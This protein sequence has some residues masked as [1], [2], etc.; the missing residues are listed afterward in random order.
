MKTIYSQRHLG[1]TGH[2][3]LSSGSLVP[4]FERPERAEMIRAEVESR[5]IGPLVEITEHGLDPVRRVHDPSFVR[6][7]SEAWDLWLAEGRDV[8]ALPSFWR[9]PGMRQIEPEAIDGK[10][11]HFSFDAGCCLVSGS[12]DAIRSSVDVALTGVDVIEAGDAVAFSLCRPPGHHA[13][14]ATMGG[15]CY[16]NNA[17]IAAQAFRDKDASRVAILDIDYHHGNG[18]QSIF[19][20]RPDVLFCSIHAEPSQEYP[21]FLG[22]EDETGTGR[23]EGFNANFRCRGGRTFEGWSDALD[24]S[25]DRV[26]GFVLR[27]SS[28]PSASI[29]SRTILSHGFAWTALTT[30]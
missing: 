4:A 24:R 17:A 3:E 21:Y 28:S 22:Y 13:H 14:A 11:G 6:F 20:D 7:L 19:Y 12:W 25:C 9:A 2:I 1:H 26:A 29:P 10:L 30:S 5:G 8:P 15:Y 16:L 23:G 27:S 18:T